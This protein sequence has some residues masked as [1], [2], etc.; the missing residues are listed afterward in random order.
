MI[1]DEVSFEAGRRIIAWKNISRRIVSCENLAR[2]ELFP[3]EDFEERRIYSLEI[4][5]M[6]ESDY[7]FNKFS[8]GKKM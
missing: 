7:A 4:S 6:L 8:K 2:I 1:M 3:W 5:E